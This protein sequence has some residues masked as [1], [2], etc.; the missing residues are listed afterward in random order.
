VREPRELRPALEA[1]VLGGKAGARE[2][3]HRP[4]GRVPPAPRTWPETPYEVK[5]PAAGAGGFK[6]VPSGRAGVR[7]LRDLW[8]DPDG[9]RRR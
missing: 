6:M 5:P 4:V 3:S 9:G 8:G 7:A 1:G 2:R